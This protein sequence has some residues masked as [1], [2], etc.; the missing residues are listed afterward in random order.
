VARVSA[1]PRRQRALAV[2][3][4]RR[5]RSRR[6]YR[7]SLASLDVM[8]ASVAQ[9]PAVEK[10]RESKERQTALYVL[11]CG[12]VGLIIASVGAAMV[13]RELIALLSTFLV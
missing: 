12:L 7:Y 6:R 11:V 13:L 10:A 2:T 3:R 4:L 1:A 5:R 9:E 8:F